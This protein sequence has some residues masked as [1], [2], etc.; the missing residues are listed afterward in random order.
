MTSWLSFLVPALLF[1]LPAQAH[2]LWL[3]RGAD[4]NGERLR[5]YFSELPGGRQ[6]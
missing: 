3:V 4:G 6:V 1:A 2:F 5:L